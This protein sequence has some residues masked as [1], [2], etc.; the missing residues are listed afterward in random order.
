MY[1]EPGDLFGK[2]FRQ[3]LG[4]AK[5]RFFAAFR[6]ALPG[7]GEGELL[8]RMH[9]AIGA[10]AHAVAGLEHLEVI[11]EGR[12]DPSDVEALLERLIAFLAAGFRTPQKGDGMNVL[13]GRR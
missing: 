5:V 3:Q 1:A 11:S 6:R 9:F 12:C 2:I 10:M 7:L 8:W 13:L 4:E